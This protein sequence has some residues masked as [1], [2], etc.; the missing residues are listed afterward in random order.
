MRRRI[1]PRDDRLGRR[2]D[3]LEPS[4]SVTIDDVIRAYEEQCAT[5]EKLGRTYRADGEPAR[6]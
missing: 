4:A 1:F 3:H 5:V 2:P 6:W